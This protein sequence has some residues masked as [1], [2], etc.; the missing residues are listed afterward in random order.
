[1][2]FIKTALLVNINF[3]E[4]VPQT[5]TEIS[6]TDSIEFLIKIEKKFGYDEKYRNFIF[7]T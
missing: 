4:S 3:L 5:S 6:L 7:S 1:M 2:I